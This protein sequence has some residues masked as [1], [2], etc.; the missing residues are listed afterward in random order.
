[1]TTI[2]YDSLPITANY[3]EDDLLEYC[4]QATWDNSIVSDSKRCN[5][6][7]PQVTL[8]NNLVPTIYQV[9]PNAIRNTYFST[10]EKYGD[11][12][13]YFK[14][15]APGRRQQQQQQPGMII[16]NINNKKYETW[17]YELIIAQHYS[18]DERYKAGIFP[19]ILSTG[20]MELL[21]VIYPPLFAPAFELDS[22]YLKEEDDDDFIG[23]KKKKNKIKSSMV[24]TSTPVSQLHS[25]S[26][27]TESD[28]FQRYGHRHDQYGR[29][30]Q[31]N[32]SFIPGTLAGSEHEKLSIQ[33][34]ELYRN[35]VPPRY[36]MEQRKR[37]VDKVVNL[38][39]RQFPK[40]K[41]RV[42]MFGSSATGLDF[43]DSDLDLCIIVPSQL[44]NMDVYDM[45]HK[46]R[47]RNSYY[48]MFCLSGLLKRGGMI[49][50]SAVPRANVPIC[51]FEDPILQIKADI[52][53]HNDMGVE[54]SK[55][56]KEYTSLDPRVRP[57]LY[58]IK[59]FT[60]MRKI[61]DSTGSTLSSY[62]Y[63]LMGLFYLMTCSPPVI[64]NL[65]KLNNDHN[66]DD[67]VCDNWTCR[68]K[69]SKP[70][71][72]LYRV[73][74]N[75][76]PLPSK[77]GQQETLGGGQPTYWRCQNQQTVGSLLVGFFAYYGL[78]FDYKTT[79]SIRMGTTIPKLPGWRKR[80]SIAVEDPFIKE[81]NVAISC[82]VEGF[83]RVI[84]E[85]Q[86]AHRLLRTNV[87]L[88]TVCEP[89][90]TP[91]ISYDDHYNDPTYTRRYESDDSQ[92]QNVTNTLKATE[93]VVKQI[94]DNYHH[95][96]FHQ[97]STT[98][99]E[100]PVQM[101]MPQP[102]KPIP[103]SHGN[104]DTIITENKN[105]EEE[106]EF[107][108]QQEH[109][110]VFD[111]RQQM[112][113]TPQV[114]EE[115]LDEDD[116]DTIEFS[117]LTPIQQRK[118]ILINNKHK[119]QTESKSMTPSQENDVKL[120]QQQKKDQELD[121]EKKK[122]RSTESE[123]SR[124]NKATTLTKEHPVETIGLIETI[125]EPQDNN[126]TEALFAESSKSKT[127]YEK[128]KIQQDE[129][130]V[131]GTL[132]SDDDDEEKEESSLEKKEKNKKKDD[133]SLPLNKEIE[134]KTVVVKKA[135]MKLM[136]LPHHVDKLDI[137]NALEAFGFEIMTIRN[138]IVQHVD[139]LGLF[140]IKEWIVRI[141]GGRSEDLPTRFEV[142][143]IML[144]KS[145]K[146][147]RNVVYRGIHLNTAFDVV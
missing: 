9:A 57:F 25:T 58:A 136:D 60:K 144:V 84:D 130:R 61:N 103:L 49:N 125:V 4:K 137:I 97:G 22:R 121:K 102:E 98:S 135:T 20:P 92:L 16:N 82:S 53:T 54:N 27:V 46:Q 33:I 105:E 59:T 29:S 146:T 23:G 41:L 131:I 40:I 116:M 72:S 31:S 45:F 93:D 101:K 17:G 63:V 138:E 37:L 28:E 74:T 64:P 94:M 147:R 89:I 120:N 52:N 13:K 118:Q 142:Q 2:F 126:T 88:D 1:M 85:F 36:F 65:Q 96:T 99:S 109:T 115:E 113:Q 139:P 143:D 133:L 34:D 66:S 108:Q 62:T 86:R 69:I 124:S 38:L 48:N 18:N 73:L 15:F 10:L 90:P 141:N 129:D 56:I 80:S 95:P 112:D 67:I 77:K 11:F 127:L 76:Q 119:R 42:E 78:V 128:K 55:L 117:P 122:I 107:M 44:F 35:S 39:R 12:V 5:S 81:R 14:T 43:T 6:S 32:D 70:K 134:T 106:D 140:S 75:D 7:W 26:A 50:I 3:E 79:L 47:E 100:T 111:A 110:I 68:S 51:K 71:L 123:L 145:Y 132:S 24:T 8:F 83:H 19:S 114:E 21:L 91:T 30:K 87:D 104:K